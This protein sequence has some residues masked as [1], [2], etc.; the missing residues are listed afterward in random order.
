MDTRSEERLEIEGLPVKAW[1]MSAEGRPFVV[2][3]V[4][5]EISYH[6]G[7]LDGV[8]S[9]LVTGETIA[10][11]FGSRKGRFRVVWIADEASECAGQ[12]GIRS[13]DDS[14]IWEAELANVAPTSKEADPLAAARRDRRQYARFR[15]PG[16]V[17]LSRSQGGPQVWAKLGDLSLGGCYIDTPVPETAGTKLWLFLHIQ[18]NKIA[19]TGEVRSC[20][21]ALGMGIQF[22]SFAAGS[23]QVLQQVI[24]RLSPPRLIGRKQ[25]TALPDQPGSL[26]AV[27]AA[28]RDHFEGNNVLTSEEFEA[29]LEA[30]AH[31]K[32]PPQNAAGLALKPA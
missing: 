31:K 6:G 25:S 1:G 15:C 21:P 20:V 17:Q 23:R 27:L 5:H 28:V 32:I 26:Q 8:N 29:I 12:V 30:V 7:R 9:R 16:N 11:Q 14:C 10:V 18:E 22:T 13:V 4:V 2:N 24:E 19:A 3:G